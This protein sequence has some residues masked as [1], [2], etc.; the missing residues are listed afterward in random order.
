M[1]EL[2][3]EQRSLYTPFHRTFSVTGKYSRHFESL[4][5]NLPADPL[6]WRHL[7]VDTCNIAE[8]EDGT[9]DKTTEYADFQLEGGVSEI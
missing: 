1:R 2:H 5:W 7:Q 8:P 6:I 9:G 4:L 3:L